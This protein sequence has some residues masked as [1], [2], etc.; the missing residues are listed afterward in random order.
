MYKP[1]DK[2]TF[3]PHNRDLT[4]VISIV[5][6]EH[7][8]FELKKENLVNDIKRIQLWMAIKFH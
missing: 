1:I 6:Q 8:L 7:D 2:R 4:T 5:I 3:I